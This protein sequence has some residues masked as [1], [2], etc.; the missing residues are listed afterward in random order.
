MSIRKATLIT[1]FTATAITA[2]AASAENN[3]YLQLNGGLSYGL[4]PKK[5]FGPKKLKTSG[6]FGFEAGY[7]ISNHLRTS[8]GLD[9]RNSY[10]LAIKTIDGIQ[11]FK[12]RMNSLAVMANFYYDITTINGFTPYITAGAGV[13]R[14]KTVGTLYH[15][16][17][18]KF[19]GAKNYFAYKLGL[20]SRYSVSEKVDIDLRYQYANLGNIYTR[21]VSHD[22][23]YKGKLHAH[24]AAIG[25][26]YKF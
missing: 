10:N 12:W 7:Q 26:S 1:I 15:E 4:A 20:G 21:N 8:L 16:D 11:D 6:L 24:E 18:F 22:E 5:D 17:A 2:T 14:N 13:A 19:N 25:I 3:Y 9:W 23:V